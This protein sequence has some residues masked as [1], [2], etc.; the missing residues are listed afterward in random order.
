MYANLKLSRA[1][2]ATCGAD[3]KAA[4]LAALSACFADAYDL[5]RATVLE[6]L[7]ERE[8]LGSTGFGRRVAIPHARVG[9]IEFPV[10]ALI[11][12]DAPV[13]FKAADGIPVDLVFGLL[14]PPNAGAG[15]L[16]ALAA[17]SRMIRDEKIYDALQRA[18]DADALFATLTNLPDSVIANDNPGG[19]ARESA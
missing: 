16:H 12:L 17:I 9:G 18:E 15:H 19:A 8:R 3:S 10:V 13:D 1:A 14:S 11:K 5:D 2:V 6:G 7:E 4:V